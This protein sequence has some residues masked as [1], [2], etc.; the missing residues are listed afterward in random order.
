MKFNI[1][2]IWLSI[3]L[4]FKL[5]PKVRDLIKIYYIYII[6]ILYYIYL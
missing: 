1:S 2:L 4:G 6:Y 5:E 3:I